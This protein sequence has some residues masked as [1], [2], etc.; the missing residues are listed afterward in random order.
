MDRMELLG[1][2]MDRKALRVLRLF[3]QN[4]DRDY[5]L[6]ESAKAARVSL[7]T[8]YRIVNRF[9]GMNVLTKQRVKHLKLYRLADSQEA[10]LLSE[11][12]EEKRTALVEFVSRA[13]AM[14]GVLMLVLHGEEGR[15]K[16]NVLIISK[17]TLP[18][19]QVQAIVAD[20]K[21]AF[22]YHII[23]LNLQPDQFN[24]MSMMGLFPGEKKIL[25]EQKSSKI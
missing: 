6:Q 19:E 12:L 10:R 4:P 22:G 8:T 13:S 18:V 24:Q 25:F 17:D 14:A 23:T 5:A 11:I 2:V 15:D 9:L 1:S 21:A 7:A 16:A 3:S 20:V